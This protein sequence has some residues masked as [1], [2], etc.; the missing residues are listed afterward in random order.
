MKPFVRL[1]S[2]DDIPACSRLLGILFDQENEFGAD[3]Q[4]QV[5]GIGMIMDNPEKGMIFVCEIDGSIQG[6]VMLLFTI[7]TFLGDKVAI[8]EDMIISEEW[9]GKGIGSL[10]LDTAIEHARNE[11]LARITLLT[12]N[13]NNPAHRFYA[14]RGFAKSDMVVFRKMLQ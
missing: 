9:R 2:R 10:L 1:A 6:M 7:S 12:D 3:P 5:R 13:D 4:K 8:L 11:G 14:S